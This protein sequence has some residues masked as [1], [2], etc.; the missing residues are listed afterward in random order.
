MKIAATA[1]IH[2]S[3]P[4][5][6]ECDLLLIAGDVCPVDAS[7]E[8]AAQRAWMAGPF[9]EWLSAAP[10][11]HKVWIAG[12]HDFGCEGGWRPEG[13]LANAATYLC[14]EEVRLDGLRIYGTPWVP[15][16]PGWAF[17][18]PE[19]EL[20]AAFEPLPAGLDILL[21]H[22]PPFGFGDHCH[23]GR[24][25][26]SSSLLRAIRERQP[27]L[28]VCGHVHEDYGRWQIGPT[29][30][31]SV[32]YLDAIYSNPRPFQLFELEPRR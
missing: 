22:G 28:A 12:N 5:V 6:P 11:Y 2:G 27:R 8:P 29:T 20:D 23:D 16:L 3:L 30:L 19:G 31:R 21:S 9:A 15:E 1:D 24:R 14:D 10:A 25:V 4:E 17:V 7:H 26:G 32:S 18:R 13:E